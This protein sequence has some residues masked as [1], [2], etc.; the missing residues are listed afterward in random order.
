MQKKA[1]CR[2]IP[3]KR[4]VQSV[5]FA[6]QGKHTRVI[7]FDPS[8]TLVGSGRSAY[9]F[10]LPGENKALKVFYPPYEQL[11][12]QEADIYQQLSGTSHY[13]IFHESGDGYL[14]IDYIEGSTFFQCLVQGKVVDS[15]QIEQ[16]DLAIEEAYSAGLNPSDI[17]LHNLILTNDGSVK[18]IDVAR[19]KQTKQCTQ[20]FDLKQAFTRYYSKRFFPK[21]LPAFVLNSIS[22]CYKKTRNAHE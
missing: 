7:A 11:A 14:V 13:P 19:F 16:V 12:V 9:V 21:R 10:K 1:H 18:V 2:S 6:K 3:V 22:T 8:L 4:L 5:R 17:H 15:K 20:W